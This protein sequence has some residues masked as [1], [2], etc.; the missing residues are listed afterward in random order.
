VSALKAAV[1]VHRH[2]A[3]VGREAWDACAGPSNP[4]VSFDFLDA[5]EQSGCAADETGWAPHHLTIEDEA[6]E[7]GHMDIG[8]ETVRKICADP[9]QKAKYD[10]MRKLGAFESAARRSGARSRGGAPRIRG[11]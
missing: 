6:G 5:L 2:I 1:R 3:D 7:G 8:E 10:R 11:P 9:E 4:F